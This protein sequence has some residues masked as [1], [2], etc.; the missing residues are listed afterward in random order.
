MPLISAISAAFCPL[1][2]VRPAP[3]GETGH[4]GTG[5]GAP[6]RQPVDGRPETARAS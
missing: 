4:T 1:T 5:T 6:A 3:L 2:V